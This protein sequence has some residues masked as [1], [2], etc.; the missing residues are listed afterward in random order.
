[1]CSAVM[2]SYMLSKIDGFAFSMS[3]D[4]IISLGLVEFPIFV[5]STYLL[6]VFF[7]GVIS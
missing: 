3:V 2:E 5:K 6:S 1:M 7:S 4:V